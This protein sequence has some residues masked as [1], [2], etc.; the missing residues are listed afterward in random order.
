MWKTV[1]EALERYVSQIYNFVLKSSECSAL[2]PFL[3]K[4]ETQEPGALG[5]RDRGAGG[6]GGALA[7]P[8][9][10]KR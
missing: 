9:I 6:A 5:T 8:M 1:L 3:G 10:Y 4:L 2:T 7:P